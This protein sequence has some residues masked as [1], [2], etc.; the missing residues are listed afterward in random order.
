MGEREGPPHMKPS[1]IQAVDHV[2][3]EAPFGSEE[4]LVWFYTEV[5]RL[6][7]AADDGEDA[8]DLCFQSARLELRIR[9]VDG[10][11][12]DPLT[13]RL[14]IVVPS[15]AEA[16]EL[17]E[18]RSIPFA[19]LSGIGYTDRRLG[20]SDPAGHRVELKQGWPPL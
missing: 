17:L 16:A 6:D 7:R 11:R 9:F 1:R 13:R 14:T 8:P 10:P 2:S 20:T 19:R 3:L 5:G 4:E 12:V 15:L 18:E